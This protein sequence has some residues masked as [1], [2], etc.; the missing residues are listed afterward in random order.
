MILLGVILILIAAAAGISFYTGALQLT[1]TVDIEVLGGS[2]SIPPVALLIAGAVIISV[3]WLGWALLR[4]GI[5]RSSRKRKEAKEAVRAAEARAT[6]QTQEA[7]TAKARAE[8]AER[9]LR[10]SPTE[11][12]PPRP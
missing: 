4:S 9:Q 2:I 10:T 7:Q 11:L 12:P 5:K 8:A 3:F 1:D 6:A